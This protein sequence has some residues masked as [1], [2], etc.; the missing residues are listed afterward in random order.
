M[1]VPQ[2]V[3]PMVEHQQE[4]TQHRSSTLGAHIFGRLAVKNNLAKYRET[5]SILPNLYHMI[6]I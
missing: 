1:I 4:Y 3:S 5:C 6:Y 2:K